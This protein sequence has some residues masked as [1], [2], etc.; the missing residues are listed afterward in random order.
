MI[1]L[2]EN[3]SDWY[4]TGEL[5][6]GS[7]SVVYAA[8]RKDDPSVHCAI[9]VITIPQDDSEYDD[10]VADGFNTELSRSFFEEAVKDFTREIRL[11]ENFKGMQNIVSIEDYK[12]VPKED[13]IGSHIFIRMELLTPLE[14]YIN[15][16]TLTEKEVIQIGT[17]ICT[18]LEF[19]QEKHIIHRDIKPANIFVNDRLGTH[20]FYKLGDFGIARNL[21]GKTQDLSTKG[22]PNYMAPEVAACMKYN[23]TADLYSLG[24]TLYWLLNGNRLPFFPQTQLYTPA[25]KREALQRRLSGEQIEPP[26]NASPELAKVILKACSYKPEDRWQTASEMKAALLKLRKAETPEVKEE[27]RKNA[28][29]P[30]PETPKKKRAVL[31]RILAAAAAL[32]LAGTGIWFLQGKTPADNEQPTEE[33]VTTAPAAEITTAPPPEATET[34][35]GTPEPSPTETL[36]QSPAPETA[37]PAANPTSDLSRFQEAD[38]SCYTYIVQEGG[39]ATITG[40]RSTKDIKALALPS[41]LDNIPVSAVAG[42]AFDSLSA[43]EILIPEGITTLRSCAFSD[44]RGLFR[45]YFPASLT[46]ITG[47]PFNGCRNLQ[48]LILSEEN[49]AF[50]VKDCV[51][52]DRN[53]RKLVI[54]IA[55][56]KD[57]I[58]PVPDTVREIGDHAF[59]NAVKLQGILLPDGLERIGNYAFAN[60]GLVMIELPEALEYIGDYAFFSTNI[61]SVKIPDRITKINRGVFY[62]CESLEEVTLP[63]HLRSIGP[64]A[65][66]AN[67]QM[68]EIRLP[69]ELEEIGHSAFSN[70]HK[71]ERIEIPASVS[72]IGGNPFDGCENLGRII[73]AEDNERFYTAD[74]VLF[75][76]TELRLITYPCSMQQSAYKVPEG[77]LIIGINAFQGNRNL[78]EVS[79]PDTLIRIDEQAFS[80]SSLTAVRLPD[81]LY[82][83]GT[84]AFL[85]CSDL[86]FV[87]LPENLPVVRDSLFAFC[88]NLTEVNIPKASKEIGLSSFFGCEQLTSLTVPAGV[89]SIGEGAFNNCEQLTVNV[90]TGSAAEQYCRDNGIPYVAFDILETPAESTAPAT[91]APAEVTEEPIP[92]WLK[93]D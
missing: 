49:P 71:L 31:P 70:C 22:T 88:S 35:T 43:D 21:E 79:F 91:E 38:E 16:K 28:A 66:S 14:K 9:K 29:E 10:L 17:D 48:E 93:D 53:M 33:P 19:C 41:T 83:I 7:Y 42:Y 81:T 87:H 55:G 65:F 62:C 46:E 61:R 77:I 76:R 18:A 69:D 60:S 85:E 73:V 8:E 27:D 51:V 47:N 86:Q 84:S 39:K 90:Q 30:A 59:D 32:A 82:E 26:V 5:G 13:G 4:V 92:D 11:M 36:T 54:Y 78:Q 15:D 74:N 75:D 44:C 40:Y 25:A 20:V 45:V 63:E 23:G 37:T 6:R 72:S 1:T 50:T 68:K 12:V 89:E 58:Y 2:P 3:W 52:F 64:Q 24:L 57:Y 56:K 34:V 67:M 80:N